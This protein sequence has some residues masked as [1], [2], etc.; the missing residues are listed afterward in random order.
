MSC[1]Y[2]GLDPKR[3]KLGKNVV[4]FPLIT[5]KGTMC[6]HSQRAQLIK[7]LKLSKYLLFTSRSAVDF[8]FNAIEKEE[9]SNHKQ[10]E[11][12]A[13]IAIGEATNASLKK[14]GFSHAA[15][16]DESTQEGVIQW[17]EEN[18]SP[19][20][21]GRIFWPCSTKARKN[22]SQYCKKR[23]LELFQWPLYS[24]CLLRVRSKPD[25]EKFERVIFTSPTTVEAF[26]LNYGLNKLLSVSWEAIGPVTQS[27]IE[28]RI[29]FARKS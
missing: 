17:I 6:S 19:R 3:Q 27:Y 16:P 10:L 13:F 14:Q 7:Q 1:L 28:K 2:L 26:C 29:E 9:L 25:L 18:I 15:L 12:K 4:H 23:S 24:T 20:S 11:K 8:F 21:K 5:T 22:L